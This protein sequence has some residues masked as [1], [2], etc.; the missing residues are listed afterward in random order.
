MVKRFDVLNCVFSMCVMLS[1]GQ[2]HAEDWPAFR[3]PLGNG[4]SQETEVPLEWSAEENILWKAPL[5]AAGNSSPI[6]SKRRTQTQPVLFRQN[7]RK[8]ALGA[9]R[10]L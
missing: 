3:G 8:A 2:L 5:P 7:K 1:T 10:K 6:V 9:H 4:I